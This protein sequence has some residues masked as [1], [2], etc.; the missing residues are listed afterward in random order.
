VKEYIKE[1]KLEEAVSDPCRIFSGNEMGF[2][3][4]PST[5]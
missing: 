5:G 2:Q 1:K 4:C 3:I